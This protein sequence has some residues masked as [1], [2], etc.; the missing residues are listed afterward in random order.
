[1]IEFLKEDKHLGGRQRKKLC[2][3]DQKVVKSSPK[4]REP[5]GR[6]SA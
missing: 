4:R 6:G 1:M 3:R 2:N 5:G